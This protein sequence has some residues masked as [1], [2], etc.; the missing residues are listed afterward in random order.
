MFKNGGKICQVHEEIKELG[1]FIPEG[2]NK[3]GVQ[4][5]RERKSRRGVQVCREIMLEMLVS[6]RSHLLYKTM[7]EPAV[8]SMDHS[9]GKTRFGDRSGSHC[10]GLEENEWDLN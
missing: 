4:K 7:P 5:H 3:V 1:V 6:K 9:L 8:G 10:P 2:K